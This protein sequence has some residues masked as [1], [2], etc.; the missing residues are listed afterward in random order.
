MGHFILEETST[1]SGIHHFHSI[2]TS[3]NSVTWQHQTAREAGISDA[4]TSIG[5][6]G[7]RFADQLA[8]PGIQ[9][10]LVMLGKYINKSQLI[11]TIMTV[12]YKV[13]NLYKIKMYDNNSIKMDEE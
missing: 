12:S 10:C 13:Q 6:G 4:T 7:N 2:C 8:M 9:Q 5:R 1:I 11:L 3:Y